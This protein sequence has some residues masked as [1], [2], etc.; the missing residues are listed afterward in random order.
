M[1]IGSSVKTYSCVFW[2]EMVEASHFYLKILNILTNIL[3]IQKKRKK[4]KRKNKEEQK[5]AN[6][7]ICKMQNTKGN[8]G[9]FLYIQLKWNCNLSQ[10][11]VLIIILSTF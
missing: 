4:G 2:R 11:K 7:L 9:L 8:W 3:G 6:T 10:H 1:M 5:M